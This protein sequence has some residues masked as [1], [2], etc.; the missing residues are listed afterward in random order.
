MTGSRSLRSDAGDDLGLL[1]EACVVP[2]P[3]PSPVGRSG[4][5]SMTATRWMRPGLRAPRASRPPLCWSFGLCLPTSKPREPVRTAPSPLTHCQGM[6]IVRTV[7]GAG[8]YEAA[9]A[10]IGPWRPRTCAAASPGN[11][12]QPDAAVQD[13]L[14]FV[15]RLLAEVATEE[16]AVGTPEEHRPLS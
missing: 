11:Y 7:P 12:R 10:D 3:M 9:A 1:M 14:E 15:A 16:R 6:G 4:Q 8:P 5:V 2:V 13:W